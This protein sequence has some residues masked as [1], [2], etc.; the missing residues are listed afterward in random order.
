M[1]ARE[2]FNQYIAGQGLRHT[3]QREHILDVVLA[4]ETHL[5][6]QELYDLVR[7]KYKGIG[8]ATVSRTL[9]LLAESGVCRAVDFADGRQRYEHKFGHEHHDHLICVECG[10]L[11]EIFSDELEELQAKLV[12]KYGYIQKSHKL[13]IFGVCPECQ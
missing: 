1:D 2:K 4:T 8:Y 10:R 6:A 13:D 9:K 11:E 5:S 3:E 7:E 12:E